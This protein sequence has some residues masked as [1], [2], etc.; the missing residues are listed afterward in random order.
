MTAY[1]N[2]I[3]PWAADLV[4]LVLD[5]DGWDRGGCGRGAGE[6]KIS[7]R[8]YATNLYDLPVTAPVVDSAVTIHFILKVTDKGTPPLTRYKR[9]V[10]TVLPK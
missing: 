8:P 4:D 5:A 9:V 6:E 3:C 10:V 2:N 7:F 1:E